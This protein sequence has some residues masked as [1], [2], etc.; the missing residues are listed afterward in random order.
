MHGESLYVLRFDL[1]FP[2][3]EVGDLLQALLQCKL[4]CVSVWQLLQ[5]LGVNL[6][7]SLQSE[8]ETND[9]GASSR[10]ERREAQ[11][12]HALMWLIQHELVSVEGNSSIYPVV[13]WSSGAEWIAL[14]SSAW[15]VDVSCTQTSFQFRFP[16]FSPIQACLL[17]GL[18]YPEQGEL[19]PPI[20]LEDCATCLQRHFSLSETEALGHAYQAVS[21]LRRR[22]LVVWELHEGFPWLEIAKSD[23]LLLP[24]V[25]SLER[26]SQASPAQR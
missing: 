17:R 18:L 15:Q 4:G 20:S 26:E 16:G 21:C 7:P 6:L 1:E 25:Y 3:R 9:V 10:C 11:F 22:G 23:P 14:R 12:W 13:C 24:G 8:A 19:V 5:D 2:Y